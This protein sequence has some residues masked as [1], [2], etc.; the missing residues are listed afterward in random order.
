MGEGEGDAPVTG[1]RELA[2][3]L[4]PDTVL[5][6]GRLP[7]VRR[8]IGGKDA[9]GSNDWPT[10]AVAV[11]RTARDPFETDLFLADTMDAAANLA[12]EDS[13]ITPSPP[14]V[15]EVT[16]SVF[17]SRAQIRRDQDV[18]A[19]FV[20]WMT[21]LGGEISQVQPMNPYEA[22]KLTTALMSQVGAHYGRL[23]REPWTKASYSDEPRLAGLHVA[24]AVWNSA[25]F[26]GGDMKPQEGQTCIGGQVQGEEIVKPI[27]PWFHTM[28]AQFLVHSI[29]GGS[30]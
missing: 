7:A 9:V 14:E 23:S 22:C 21:D 15:H 19:W 3:R 25:S 1:L 10:Q 26:F 5:L 13:G 17:D 20:L 11:L 2:A 27:D 18:F 6:C 29:G 30:A 24:R 12:L 8:L 28:A 16:V 4:N